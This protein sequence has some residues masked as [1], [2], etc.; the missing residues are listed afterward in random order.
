MRKYFFYALGEIVLITVGILIALQINS[1]SQERT[2]RNLEKVFLNRLL[3]DLDNDIETFNAEV[4]AG[5]A[6]L[7]AIKEAVILMDQIDSEEKVIEFNKL[8]DLTFMVTLSPHYATY[9]ELEST[10]RLNIIQSDVLRSAIQDHYVFYE[11]MEEE[12]AH[13]AWYRKS[14]ARVMDAESMILKYAGGVDQLFPPERRLKRDWAFF[15]NPEYPEYRKTEIALSA[16]GWLINY[17]LSL[18]F[19]LLE[20]IHVLKEDIQ[21]ELDRSQD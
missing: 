7:E 5:R 15:Q 11:R 21:T 20:R 19:Q 12:F 18:Y 17:D 2:D 6:G 10:G 14:V 9:H 4:E 3:Q 1:W 8:Y 16:G 13:H